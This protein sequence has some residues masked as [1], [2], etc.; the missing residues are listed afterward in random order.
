MTKKLKE[1]LDLALN[2]L[3]EYYDILYDRQEDGTEEL[4]ELIDFIAKVIKKD[5]PKF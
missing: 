5:G 2:Y 3:S 4:K 1:K